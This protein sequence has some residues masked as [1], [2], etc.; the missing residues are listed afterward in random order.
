MLQPKPGDRFAFSFL[1]EEDDLSHGPVAEHILAQPR[2]GPTGPVA[3]VKPFTVTSAP[4]T[5]LTSRA[6]SSP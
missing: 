6:V 1:D 2:G 5:K 3:L 4:T